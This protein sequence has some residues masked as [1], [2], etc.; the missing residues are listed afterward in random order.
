MKKI[1]FM[2]EWIYLQAKSELPFFRCAIFRAVFNT[3][4]NG[5]LDER[6]DRQ[7]QGQT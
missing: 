7:A 2:C 5:W 1:Q 4:L 3:R 6:V